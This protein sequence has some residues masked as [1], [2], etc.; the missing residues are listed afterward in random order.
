MFIRSVVRW[1]TIVPLQLLDQ[2]QHLSHSGKML[3]RR[4]A[5]HQ[6]YH[7]LRFGFAALIIL[8]LVLSR[9][10]ADHRKQR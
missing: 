1:P 9:L 5:K 8:L 7:W 4:S 10:H 6:P 2:F 3:E